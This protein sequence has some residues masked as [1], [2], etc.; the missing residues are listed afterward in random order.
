M[1][2]RPERYGPDRVVAAWL[3][4]V[5][6]GIYLLSFSG[7]MYSQDSMSMF[8]VT[9]SFVKRGELNT[10]QMW[11]LF[12]ARNEIA[13]DGESYSK[14]GYGMSLA[15]AP[16][17]AAALIFPGD[18]GLTQSAMLASSVVIALAG[19]LLFLA[20]RELGCSR[21]VGLLGAFLFGLATP[22]WVYAK[23]LWSE[24]FAL[25]FLFAAFYGLIHFRRTERGSAAL[26]AGLAL[27]LAMATRVTNAALIPVFAWYGFGDCWQS[28]RVRRGLVLFGAT[29]ALFALS[30]GWYDWVRYG[31][32]LATGYRADETFNTP[33]LVG[34]YGLLFSPGKGLFVY[35]P[36]LA[37]LPFSLAIFFRRAR[38]EVIL[39]LFV[40]AFYLFTFALWYYW[41]GGTN[42]GPRFLVPALPFLILALAPVVE[43]VYA[44]SGSLRSWFRRPL[45]VVFS[46]LVLAGVAIELLGITV[47][48][49]SYRLRMLTLSS[50]PDQDAMFLPQ[51]SPLIGYFNL[52]KP[53]V[54][55][56]AWIRVVDNETRI[57]WFV[58]LVTLAFI[59]WCGVALWRS[60]RREQTAFKGVA[61]AGA[62]A[63]LLILVSLARYR[64]DARF[65]GG[66]GY[67]AL[68]Q[69]VEQA[70][71]P[72]DVMVLD[73]DVHAPFFFNEN[74]AAIRWYGLSRDPKQWD[75][76]TRA[77]LVR[78]TRQYQRVWFVFDDS[79]RDLPDPTRTWLEQSLTKIAQHDF[80][81]QV[82]LALYAIH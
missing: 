3:A 19:A 81:D 58:I 25:F 38:R 22:A 69:T 27:G 54:L 30:I 33:L 7:Q 70:A 39:I 5:L 14:Y 18:L 31:N 57:D 28:P 16:F 46:L 80:P 17:Y 50:N 26:F 10:D 48:A 9:E 53:R 43:R 72:R 21:R 15:A 24:P 34:L 56:F 2:Q 4:L 37:V 73:N 55:D 76:S 45:F 82:H 40:F 29:L 23:Q 59:T 36:F 67:R 32:P 49:L 68:L 60:L 41:W 20:A 12:K 71:E 61:L 6:F 52:L 44:F 66:D 65:G 75:E 13:A 35:V 78:L 51:F 42:W 63:I 77:L 8:S 64:D 1:N 74:R 47:P 11:T 79:T 62:L